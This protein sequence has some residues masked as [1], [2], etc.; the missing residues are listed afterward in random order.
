MKQIEAFI[1]IH[2]KAEFMTQPSFF[3]EFLIV[4]IIAT[5]VAIIFERIRLSPIL[6]FLL[7]GVVVGPH[8]FGIISDFEKTHLLADLGVILLMLTIGLEF[9]FERLKGV[10]HIAILGGT[11][12][13]LLS[14][15]IGL[16]FGRVKGWSFYQGFVLGSVIA[17]SSTALVLKYFIDRGE[18][19]TR[20]SQIAVA[21]LLF[22]D[23][24]VVPLIILI[25][26]MGQPAES[27]LQTLGIDFLKAL[28]LV[29]GVILFSKFILPYVLHQIALSRN[30]EIF[31]LTAIVIC[32]GSAWSSGQMG[33]SLAIGAFLA[34]L[35]FA[36]TDYGHQ[37][38]GEILPFRHVFVS[39]F[40]VSIGLLFNAR[41]AWEHVALILMMVGLVLLAN[42][43]VMTLI[44][45]VFRC[46]LR[47]ALA[48]ALILSQIGEFSFLL[49]EAARN[50]GGIDPF[51]YQLLLSTAFLTM[52][53][54]PFLFSLVPPILRMSEHIPE[55]ALYE[56][57]RQHPE[58]TTPGPSGHIILCGFGPSGRDLA[59]TFREEKLPFV[60][61]EL[62]PT[63]IKEARAFGMDVIYG[64]AA[65]EEVMKQA[66][67]QFAQAVVVSFGDP[68]GMMQ[69]IGIVERLN[70]NVLLVVRTRFEKDVPKLYEAGADR[71]VM[72]ELEASFE[73]NRI[74]LEHFGIPK[75]NIERHCERIQIRKELFIETAILKRRAK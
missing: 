46:A 17:P 71:V 63:S 16:G 32:L 5:L 44:F 57:N 18:L 6:G 64:D 62:N 65:N 72:E 33:L 3:T 22:Q 29:T 4:L 2:Q 8:G 59:M 48:T 45:L 70:P 75:E 13:I 30:R 14:I 23:L 69:I 61:I 1:F 39:I 49:L 38:S 11:L 37:L 73:L 41:F 56:K 7:A 42:F 28:S 31:L 68:I 27:I 15:L 43:V 47:I 60:V 51:F 21:I 66:G 40:F 24:A 55:F 74:V 58:K 52:L 34:G 20:H 19:D 26:G 50:S 53:I 12:Q 25:T 36:N 9:S 54:T 35:M 67:I 10:Q